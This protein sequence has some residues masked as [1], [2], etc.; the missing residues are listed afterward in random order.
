MNAN[1]KAKPI[2]G[3]PVPKDVPSDMQATPPEPFDFQVGEVVNYTNGNGLTACAKI[4]GFA[5]ERTS[6]GGFVYL[7]HWSGT[8]WRLG[9]WWVP[10]RPDAITRKG[11]P[12]QGVGQ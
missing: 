6:Y 4:R 8:G 1:S 2:H 9:A 11:L 7:E 5:K 12:C 3:A 10:E